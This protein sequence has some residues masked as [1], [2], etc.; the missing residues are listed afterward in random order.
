MPLVNQS[1][2]FLFSNELQILNILLSEYQ[3]VILQLND[4]KGSLI[5]TKNAGSIET[6]FSLNALPKGT[7]IL[8]ATK[9]GWME[10]RKLVLN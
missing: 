8:S 7:Y 2:A 10:S 4:S 3:D 5:F 9:E 1:A 6:N